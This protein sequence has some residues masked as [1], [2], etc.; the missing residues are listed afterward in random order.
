M[1]LHGLSRRIGKV[2]SGV[3]E[4]RVVSSVG[5][6]GDRKTKDGSNLQRIVTPGRA[7]VV[8]SKSK[9]DWEVGTYSD[10]RPMMPVVH[11]STDSHHDPSQKRRKRKPSPGLVSPHR[12]QVEFSSEVEREEPQASK[13]QRAVAGRETFVPISEDVGVGLG[14]DRGVGETIWVGVMGT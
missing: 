13:G 7:S 6:V 11:R 8:N 10:I 2:R 12:K 4:R 5:D 9:T 1:V 3:G 14:A